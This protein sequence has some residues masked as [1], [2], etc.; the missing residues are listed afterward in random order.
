M[1]KDRAFATRNRHAEKHFCR[2]LDG[3]EFYRRFPRPQN[4]KE[5]PHHHRP[6]STGI[7]GYVH[8]DRHDHDDYRESDDEPVLDKSGEHV[9]VF[10]GTV[11]YV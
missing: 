7:D 11:N 10:L 2:S 1:A 8:Y 3:L 5:G 9:G 4:Q 6:Y